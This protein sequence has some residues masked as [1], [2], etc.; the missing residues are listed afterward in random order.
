MY[1]Y[2]RVTPFVRY[3]YDKSYTCGTGV[4]CDTSFVQLL[5][6]QSPAGVPEQKYSD[7][8]CK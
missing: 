3:Q 6:P 8:H 1:C 5:C 2:L 4:Q 7:R